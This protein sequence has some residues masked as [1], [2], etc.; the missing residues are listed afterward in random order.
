M[1]QKFSL[2]YVKCEMSFRNPSGDVAWEDRYEFGIQERGLSQR[3]KSEIRL[4]VDD[5]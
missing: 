4:L 1:T 2:E 5:I 3:Y